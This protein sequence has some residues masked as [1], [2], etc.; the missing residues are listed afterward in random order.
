M[1]RG[2]RQHS[3]EALLDR[4]RLLLARERHLTCEII[5]A[6]T[7]GPHI[8]IY[9]R[10]FGGLREAYARIGF[11][12]PGQRVDVDLARRLSAITKSISSRL[13]QGIAARGA[14]AKRRRCRNGSIT[15]NNG[16]TLS[17]AVG[18]FHPTPARREP[19]WRIDSRRRAKARL[20]LIAR[21]DERNEAVLDYYLVPQASLRT[22]RTELDH[23]RLR[24]L[25]HCRVK[26]LG[27]A[28]D[29]LMAQANAKSG[30]WSNRKSRWSKPALR[31]RR[32]TKS[33]SN[34]RQFN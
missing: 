5:R 28:I 30:S 21:L 8:S 4:L 9:R 19:R 2:H 13:L 24:A 29:R 11:T 7:R 17:I 6:D 26:D 1:R 12:K 15:I 20:A 33:S 27:S 3:D 23:D 34:A 31:V 32:A 14:T 10:R 16:L 25:R 18:K 22:Y